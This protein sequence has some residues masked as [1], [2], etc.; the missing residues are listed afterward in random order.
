MTVN[1][2][3]LG[4]DVS[5]YQ[6]VIDWKAVKQS[7]VVFA[8]IKATEGTT[9]IDPFFERNWYGAKN[10]GLYRGAYHFSRPAN[11][12]ANNE[13]DF[14]MNAIEIRGG[15]EEGDILIQDMEAGSGDLSGWALFFQQVVANI[16]GFDPL[17]YSNPDFIKTRQLDTLDLANYPLWLASYRAT[18]PP[19]PSK[20]PVISFWQ[21]SNTGQIAGIS[22]NVDL[23]RFNGL[24]ERISLFGMPSQQKPTMAELIERLDKIKDGIDD[25]SAMMKEAIDL[26]HQV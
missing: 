16:A 20:W 25:V 26:A 22:G 12:A 6:G 7:G 19:V 17:F 11:N 15:I 13:A 18:F 2:L 8:F 5:N 9:F 3:P 24:A 14:F 23:N 1:S 4:I 21:Y 10:A